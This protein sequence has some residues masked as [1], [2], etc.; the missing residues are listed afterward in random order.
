MAGLSA[1]C[2]SSS[3]PRSAN[4]VRVQAV[5]VAR[6]HLERTV[7]G[8]DAAEGH[9]EHDRPT[10]VGA[11]PAELPRCG[12][13]RC[14]PRRQMS[15][16]RKAQRRSS[17]SKGVSTANTAGLARRSGSE[18]GGCAA[19]GR[20]ATAPLAPR[21]PRRGGWSAGT[22]RR[23]PGSIGSRRAG[24]RTRRRGARPAPTGATG[25]RTA[26]PCSTS[27]V[28]RR[29]RRRPRTGSPASTPDS[30]ARW[31]CPSSSGSTLRA[32]RGETSTRTSIVRTWPRA[33]RADRGY[34]PSDGPSPSAS[35]PCC[36]RRTRSWRCP[37]Q[38]ASGCTSAP[39]SSPRRRAAAHRGARRRP[40]AH[41]HHDRRPARR[42]TRARR[43][44]RAHHGLRPDP[45]DPAARTAPSTTSPGSA[46]PT[47]RTRRRGGTVR[48]SLRATVVRRRA[49]LDAGGFDDRWDVFAE[50]VLAAKLDAGGRHMGV[51]EGVEI[52][53]SDATDIGTAARLRPAA[54]AGARRHRAAADA[55]HAARY[56]DPPPD[57]PPSRRRRGH[58]RRRRRA[59][60]TLA[61][62][63]RCSPSRPPRTGGQGRPRGGGRPGA[64]RVRPWRAG[65]RRTTATPPT[66]CG[67]CSAAPPN[68]PRR[69]APAKPPTQPARPG[70]GGGGRCQRERRAARLRTHRGA[71]RAAPADDR[72]SGPAARPGARRWRRGRD[73]QRRQLGP[74]RPDSSSR[75]TAGGRNPRPWR[76]G[77]PAPAG[78]PRRCGGSCSVARRSQWRRSRYDPWPALESATPTPAAAAAGSSGPDAHGRAWPRKRTARATV[79]AEAAHVDQPAS[80]MPRWAITLRTTPRPTM[81]IAEMI[82]SSRRGPG[83]RRALEGAPARRRRDALREDE[84]D[85]D[86]RGHPARRAEP[87]SQPRREH[88]RRPAT[89]AHEERALAVQARRRRRRGSP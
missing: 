27:D 86:G 40:A 26:T 44:A 69:R 34:S 57:P 29:R 54:T 20:S 22:T 66:G 32:R 18:N 21:T 77:P 61:E 24:R 45:S 38:P 51:E 49:F 16:D 11:G 30:M 67:G 9:V 7:L 10:G 87:S 5:A 35:G 85:G 12:D 23:R 48:V 41:P 28:E 56:L 47:T 17:P 2:W 53:H 37:A 89:V 75:S 60:S 84:G 58:A 71:R 36:D 83:S 73:R 1:S 42:R 64:S 39:P 33:L 13:C 6:P 4:V 50:T 3:S 62:T 31:I 14:E 79:V 78:T 8:T 68:R 19:A 80:T 82:D 65:P 81:A 15:L 52:L 70:R 74:A 76:G 46:S 55:D 63:P 25:G 72:R 59:G 88:A 43:D